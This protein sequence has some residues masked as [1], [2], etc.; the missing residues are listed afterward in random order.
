MAPQQAHQHHSQVRGGEERSS[1]GEGSVGVISR[2]FGYVRQLRKAGVERRVHTAGDS[3]AGLDPFLSMKRRDLSSQ[4]RLR[5][6]EQA[7]QRAAQ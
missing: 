3:K 4:R 5:R 6:R 7:Q 2:G 1:S